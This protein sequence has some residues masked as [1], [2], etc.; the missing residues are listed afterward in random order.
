MS[1]RTLW[2]PLLLVLALVSW[3]SPPAAR[4]D[5]VADEADLQFQLGADAYGR[6][7]FRGALEHFLA[8]NRLVPNRNV[9]FNIAR[10]FEQLGRFPDSYRYYVDALRGETDAAIVREVEQAI[11][12]ISPKV[13]VVELETSPPGATVYV[14][15]RDLG[16][17]GSTPARLGL[18]A[19]TYS[20]LVELPGYE[21]AKVGPF[22]LAA[23]TRTPIRA[24]LTLIVGALA[25]EGTP[26][27]ELRVDDE[28]AP[29]ACVTPC[30]ID[31]APGSHQ[32]YFT[33]A[34]FRAAPRLVN[35]VA[36]ETVTVTADLTAETGAILVSTD[37]PN[38][39]IEVDGH[40]VGFAPAVVDGI[41]VGQR[42]VRVSLRGFEPIERVV[43]VRADRQ[44]DLAN[45]SLEPLRQVSAASRETQRIEDAPA[46]VTIIDAQELEAFAYPTILE[47]LRGVRGI[48]VNY[49]SI[50][51]NAAVRGL[52]Q[53]NDY[54]NRLLVLSDGAVL[55]ENV[56]YQPFIHYD[57]RVDL[58][59]VE[60]IEIVRGPASVLYGTG[61]VS[62]VVNLVM[63]GRDVPDGT[64]VQVSSYDNGTARVRGDATFHQ[65]EV[66]GWVSLAL[67]R[68]GG[69]DA[70]LV[71]DDGSGT[72]GPHVAHELDK[73]HAW[74]VTGKAWW[75]NVT[76][77]TFY[78]WRR[79]TVPTGS[80]GAVFDDPRNFSDDRRFL[81][82]LKYE[83]ALSERAKLTLRG[84]LDYA[85][86]HQDALYDATE[87]P[88]DPF[89][90][91]YQETY[92]SW[93]TGAEARLS[94]TLAKDV[95]L[96]LGVE[97]TVHTKVA[98]HTGQYE[99]DGSW[100]EILN[101]DSPYQVLAGYALLDWK[102]G[103]R[104][105][106]QAGA[107]FDYWNLGGNQEAVP[108]EDNVVT[109]FPAVSPRVALVLKPRT[110][111]VVKVM[112]GT[113]FRAPSA[114][115]YY[116]ADGGAS[117]AASSVCGE[118]LDPENVYSGEVEASHRFT[119]DWV[120]LAAAHATYAAHI[121][122]TV[123][124]PMEARCGN[125]AGQIP[126]EVGYYRNSPV[127][128]LI[129]GGD[130][131]LRREWRAGTMMSL[132]YGVLRARYTSAPDAVVDDR[133]LPNSATHYA[134]LKAVVPLVQ[135][136]ANGA[137]RVTFE[138]RRRVDT[139][140]TDRTPRAVIAD[141]VISG[142][143]GRQGVRYAAGLYN[144]FDW[145]YD[146][147]AFPYATDLMPQLGRSFILSV[148]YTR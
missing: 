82:E 109:S 38:A 11:A 102:L 59:D 135:N 115:E 43:E 90:Q 138:D 146:L 130:L 19:G 123:P 110:A 47:S 34:G 51:G 13:A 107:R 9:M 83:G 128:Q 87:D 118:T 36:R 125:D 21:P 142:F 71:F 144:L 75:K 112:G 45:L 133:T 67:A 65:G 7:D 41:A 5:G 6:N 120:G 124:V 10:S 60:R 105:A 148:G 89:L 28:R 141:L 1:F 116:Y 84:Y 99:R 129:L 103:P 126:E 111:D 136:L 100:T 86:Y 55:N 17:V 117:Q 62:G 95:K 127:G 46:S 134:G 2:L 92:R 72:A 98:M 16:S 137:L 113:G 121:I 35:V 80:F 3:S 88:A 69:R 106:L 23:G 26:G 14:E 108:G 119:R 104:A 57:G 93:W 18:A 58:G 68:S 20:F 4:A 70:T 78:T 145:Q 37:E 73:F 32:L 61:A 97:G 143:V 79:L 53:A 42:T 101:V 56:L 147:P 131:E 27:T 77:Q 122:E 50:Y 33:R 40:P 30:K 114:F 91:N 44:V 96:A 24:D 85:Y 132:F 15:R 76:V 64:H 52:G 66:G 39:L 94:L 22:T 139:E 49:D 140:D 12:R 25:V 48:A 81:T 74:T 54:N 63:R 31:L 8:S 29:P